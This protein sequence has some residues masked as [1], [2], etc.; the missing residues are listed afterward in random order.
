MWGRAWRLSRNRLPH[1]PN[2]QGRRRSGHG[3]RHAK[4][5]T[6]REM[7]YFRF[8][9]TNT[10]D[11]RASFCGRLQDLPS[12]ILVEGVNSTL[13]HKYGG[14]PLPFLPLMGMV[15]ICERACKEGSL[16]MC[17]FG[18]LHFHEA[19]RGIVPKYEGKLLSTQAMACGCAFAHLAAKPCLIDAASLPA[20][21]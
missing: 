20:L 14:W 7:E 10:K 6:A 18:C 15:V 2:G 17:F 3:L 19:E 8:F 12:H 1:R 13:L 9:P 21:T 16:P 5:L 11:T 4:H